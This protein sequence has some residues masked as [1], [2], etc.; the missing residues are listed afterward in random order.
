MVFDRPRKKVYVTLPSLNEVV[1]VSTETLTVMDRVIVGSGPRGIDLSLDG[2]KLFVALN[3]TGAVAVVDI[4]SKTIEEIVVGDELE[5]PRTWDVLEAQPNRLFVTAGGSSG[6]PHVIQVQLDQSN[7]ISRVAGGRSTTG[8]LTK[9]PDQQFVYVGEGF[10]PN[11]LYKLDLSEASA[12][13]ILEDDHGSVNGTSSLTVNPDGKRI[14]TRS[15]QILNTESFQ[16][17]AR[18]SSGISRYGED[19]QEFFV[20]V[21]PSNF[22]AQLNITVKV[23]DSTI[24]AERHTWTLSCPG[25]GTERNNGFVILPN[26]ESF[27]LL[28]GDSLCHVFPTQPPTDFNSDGT[29]DFMWRNME[30]GATAVW[31]MNEEGLREAATF[32]G[33]AGL[34]WLVRGVGD[35]NNDGIAD[36][37]W[38]NIVDGATA[39]W[40]MN[41]EGLRETTTFP[42]AAGLAW[43]IRGVADVNRD[44]TADWIWHN[45][46]NGATAVWLMNEEGLRD[47][48][49]FPGGAGRDWTIKGVD[50]FNGDEHAD[51]LWRNQETG[52]TAVWLMNKDGARETATFPGGAG[53]EWAIRGLG[54]INGDGV[55][56]LVWRNIASGATAVWLMRV[57]GFRQEATFPG[58]A[59][60]KWEIHQ[61]G[62]VNGDGMADLVW[63]NTESG[64]TAVWLMDADGLRQAVIYP[65]G[66]GLAWQ[67]RS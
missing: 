45:T 52:A 5:S 8:L 37:V 7:A 18:V 46:E 39:V 15:G 65:G 40:L 25:G 50:D 19:A 59:D 12:P 62:D 31:L 2:S 21:E 24:F 67:L 63:R 29:A 57:A 17:I 23:F 9:S 44:G 61:V 28:R 36:F 54:D 58:G 49:T 27:L 30:N 43:S 3:E 32:P 38:R 48:A 4:E 66:A 60:L 11:S 20:A 53:L 51:L 34:D 10:S 47:S 56:D 33:G 13:I 64:A 16:E 41:E 42:G 14:H 1:Y 26:N 6:S 55:A 35:V 22:A